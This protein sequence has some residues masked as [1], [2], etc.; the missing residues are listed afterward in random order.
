MKPTLK[1]RVNSKTLKEWFESVQDKTIR[2]ELLNNTPEKSLIKT[3]PNLQEA[4]YTAF[5]WKETEQGYN[6]WSEFTDKVKKN[7]VKLSK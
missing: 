5:R 4:L 7:E 1:Y 2:Q 3:A 6:Y